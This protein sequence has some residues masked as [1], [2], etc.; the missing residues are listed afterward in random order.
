VNHDFFTGFLSTASVSAE[1]EG[2]AIEQDI[3]GSLLGHITID[4]VIHEIQLL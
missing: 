3:G 4:Q 1:V 2:L